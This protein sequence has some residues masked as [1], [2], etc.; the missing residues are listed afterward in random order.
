M[1][2]HLSPE[3]HLVFLERT[4][5]FCSLRRLISYCIVP[6]HDKYKQQ[7]ISWKT[8]YLCWVHHQCRNLKALWS[9]SKTSEE[10]WHKADKIK[11]KEPWNRRYIVSF[12]F[13]KGMPDDI[14]RY[15]WGYGTYIP[16]C[17]IWYATTDIL[18]LISTE[19][20][21]CIWFLQK[22]STRLL[23]LVHYVPTWYYFTNNI[24]SRNSQNDR[25]RV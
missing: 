13:K 3:R 23:I 17:M 9:T 2:P 8:N 10:E 14:S 19:P 18:Q 24:T 12:R 16:I 7:L 21:Q 6:W 25:L 20:I 5:N 1:D 15:I 22:T 4:I 11:K